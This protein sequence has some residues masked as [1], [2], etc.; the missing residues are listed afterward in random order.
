M[1]RVLFTAFIL[2]LGLLAFY[3]MPASKPVEVR[4]WMALGVPSTVLLLV[5]LLFLV[6][7]PPSFQTTGKRHG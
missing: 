5:A 4:V 6:V 3:S 7:C 2:G 1:R